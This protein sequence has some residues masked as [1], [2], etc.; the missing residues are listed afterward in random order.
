MPGGARNAGAAGPAGPALP[1]ASA[2]DAWRREHPIGEYGAIG[3]CKTLALVSPL[4]SVDWLCLPH[5][6]GPSVFGALVDRR[7]GGRFVVSAREVVG[8]EQHYLDDSNVLCTRLRCRGGTLELVD[9]LTIA[10][11]RVAGGELQ[12]AH[13]LLRRA[14]CVEGQVDLVA[15]F[16]PRPEYARRLPRLAARGRLGWQCTLGRTNVHLLSDLPWRRCGN[17]ALWA[18]VRLVAG[19]SRQ[20]ALAS[21]EHEISVLAP[22]GDE[23]ERRIAETTAWWRRWTG[24]CTYR[25]PY[26]DAVLRSALALKM[27]SYSLSGALVAAG[28]TSIPVAAQGSRNWDYRHCWLRDSSLVLQSF[29][30]LGYRDEASAFL[31][32]LLHATRLTRPRL[33]V[34]YDVF[35]ESSLRERELPQLSGHFGIGPVRV[36]NAASAQ[37]QLD[38]YGE[39]VLTAH[40]FV[41]RGG[42]LAAAE[43]A[44]LAGFAHTAAASWREPDHGIWEIRLPPRHNTHSKLMCWAA[45]DRALD[46]HARIGLPV[47][48]AG[49]ARERELVRADIER[50]AWDPVQQCYVGHYGGRSVDASL[51]LIPRL[52]YL[53]ADDPR[54]LGTLAQIERRLDGQGLLYR[55]SPGPAEDGVSGGEGM[56]VICSFWHVECLA[57]IGRLDEARAKFERLLALRSPTGLLSEEV[58][59][60]TRRLVG[61]YPQAFSHVGLI[62]AALALERAS[63]TPPPAG[64]PAGDTRPRSAAEQAA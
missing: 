3:D 60:A 51:L 7:Y 6:A 5:F 42:R 44:L 54:M 35:G 52:G 50:H 41:R 57:R 62:T 2:I 11:D 64:P 29:V 47:D 8:T 28:T 26:R 63:G 55:Y 53:P 38:V 61:N 30:E 15:L 45:I 59:P 13:E 31:S 25:G 43:R 36:G 4:G 18:E 16:E 9:S 40:E 48:A 49:L 56:F 20:A 27:L 19:E 10:P 22:L 39:I 24:C 34:V 21:C 32:W 17:A 14:R 37:Q 33:Q 1:E 46:L 23:L 12:P 58:Q